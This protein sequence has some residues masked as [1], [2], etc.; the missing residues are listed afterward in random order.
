MERIAAP[1]EEAYRAAKQLQ[2][3]ISYYMVERLVVKSAE[4]NVYL[5]GRDLFYDF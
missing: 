5:F 3:H 4:C 1:D 2:G